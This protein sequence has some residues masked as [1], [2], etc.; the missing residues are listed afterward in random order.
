M[1]NLFW[2]A[3]R[4]SPAAVALSLAS[5]SGAFAAEVSKTAPVDAT[6]KTIESISAVDGGLSVED[7]MAPAVSLDQVQSVSELSDVQPT[8]WAF[9]A[10]QLLI[11][12]YG[13]IAGYPDGTF[14]GNRALSR[15]EFAAGVYAC[16]TRM[17]ELLD[18]YTK[19][20]VKKEDL[21]TLRKLQETFAAE[22]ATL[23]GRVDSI[24]ARTA[25]L[26]ANQFS[27]TTKLSGTVIFAVAGADGWDNNY[28]NNNA[29][30]SNRVRLNFNTS[31]N[32][33]DLLRT[34]LQTANTPRYF[35][36][37][38]LSLIHI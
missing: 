15:Y 32:G 22:L 12:R 36:D 11:E 7:P 38:T 35:G 14:K 2:N 13:C 6:Q 5:A 1:S 21:A 18:S 20:L 26:E 29:T 17:S 3:L 24:E 25:E 37:V 4:L 23:R 34:R 30:F 31:F 27:T 16:L 28:T 9:Q 8:D 33:R 10:L 19:D